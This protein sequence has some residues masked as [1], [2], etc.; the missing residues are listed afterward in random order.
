MNSVHDILIHTDHPNVTISDV[1]S[2]SRCRYTC[3]TSLLVGTWELGLQT[4]INLPDVIY[5]KVFLVCLLI[6]ESP[7]PTIS[8]LHL[9]CLVVAFFHCEI[10]GT[11]LCLSCDMTVHVGGKRTHGR[12]LLLRQSVEVSLYSPASDCN[13]LNFSSSHSRQLSLVS[14]R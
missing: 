1:S 13:F 3:V 4:L 14:R 11:S 6:H 2:M 7:F 9:V 10:D 12:Y 8:Q 5:A